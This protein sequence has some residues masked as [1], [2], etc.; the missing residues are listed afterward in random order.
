[1]PS[2]FEPCGLNQM[3][4]LRYGT[5]PV[6][7]AVGGLADT[8]RDADSVPRGRGRGEPTGFVFTDYTPQALLA[9][10]RRA[11]AAYAD[12]VKW[13]ALQ[14]AGMRQD[15]S[16][17]RSAQEYVKI[18]DRVIGREPSTAGSRI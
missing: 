13:R 1:M 12:P 10:L 18:Y 17:D 11:L 3:Y 8:V 9:A 15:Y 4:S 2:R 7:R 5:V 16:W 14:V 6:V